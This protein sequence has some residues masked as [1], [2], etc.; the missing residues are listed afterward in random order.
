MKAIIKSLRRNPLVAAALYS[1]ARPL[2]YGAERLHFRIGRHVHRNGGT[3]EYDGIP[4]RFPRNVGIGFLAAI[5]WRGVEGFEPETWKTLRRLIET[6]NTFLDIGANIGLYSVLAKRVSP[7]IDV[8][9]FEP[10]PAIA[11]QSRAFHMANAI[12]P[13]VEE[14]GLSDS[15]GEA[16]L[17]TPH[18]EETSSSTL[19]SVSWQ[20]RNPHE[21]FT[22]RTAKLDSYLSGR[23]L[24]EPVTIK[25]D[26]EDHEAAVLRGA[27]ETIRHYRPAIVCEILPRAITRDNQPGGEPARP[28]EQHENA[29]TLQV[30]A[31]IGY[32]AFAITADGYFRMTAADFKG[33]RSFRDCLLLPDED[34]DQGRNYFA[35]L[36]MR[37]PRRQDK[38]TPSIG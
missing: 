18:G 16:R 27:T 3:A 38:G 37:H 32:T 35:G 12:A 11:A 1:V 25:I 29:A 31:D 36:P 20:A 14:I 9:S 15:D 5:S 26:V 8:I 6:S 7:S 33:D 28:G 24:R 30:L 2:Y 22:V 13:S 4:L 34:I 10:M 17:F 21:E 23:R 19:S